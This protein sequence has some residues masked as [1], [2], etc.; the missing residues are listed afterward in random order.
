MARYTIEIEGHQNELDIQPIREVL[1]TLLSKRAYTC[2]IKRSVQNLSMGIILLETDFDLSSLR[3][4]LN[5]IRLRKNIKDIT[6]R[7]GWVVPD[8]MVE[9]AQLEEKEWDPHYFHSKPQD[10]VSHTY[11]D[12]LIGKVYSF[13]SLTLLFFGP[14]N[15]PGMSNVG[16]VSYPNTTP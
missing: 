5:E 13:I 11:K 12:D 7:Y 3:E 9:L 10:E 4:Q 2:N 6:T 8:E 1:E 14:V 16:L 15:C